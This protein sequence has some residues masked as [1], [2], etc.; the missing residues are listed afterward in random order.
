MDEGISRWETNPQLYQVLRV[1]AFWLDSGRCNLAA[2]AQSNL[3]ILGSYSLAGNKSGRKEVTVSRA[4]SE[5]IRPKPRLSPTQSHGEGGDNHFSS[6]VVMFEAGINDWRLAGNTVAIVHPPIS[7]ATF[8][9]ELSLTKLGLPRTRA[10]NSNRGLANVPAKICAVGS[11]R[12]ARRAQ[13]SC[14]IASS[15]LAH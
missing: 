6:P 9:G 3:D 15:K 7:L 2:L 14:K 10:K 11:D 8:E 13:K 12:Q 5:R 1:A 4:W